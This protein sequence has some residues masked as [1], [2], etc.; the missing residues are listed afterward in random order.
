MTVFRFHHTHIFPGCRCTTD[1]L[2]GELQGEH[3]ATAEFSDGSIVGADF[4][5]RDGRIAITVE[6]Y[7]TARG[8]RIGRKS[9]ALTDTGEK[10]VWKASGRLASD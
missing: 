10:G 6:S 8:T 4:H 5:W 7:M 9:W 3:Q 2:V 1:G